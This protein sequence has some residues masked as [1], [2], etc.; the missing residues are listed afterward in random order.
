MFLK[1]FQCNLA[2]VCWSHAVRQWS[3]GCNRNVNFYFCFLLFTKLLSSTAGCQLKK[4]SLY[5]FYQDAICKKTAPI[6]VLPLESLYSLSGHRERHDTSADTNT[7]AEERIIKINVLSQ[8]TKSA[9]TC[10][11]ETCQTRGGIFIL[12]LSGLYIHKLVK[13]LFENVWN[14]RIN[15]LWQGDSQ[16]KHTLYKATLVGTSW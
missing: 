1:L 8:N 4:F 10:N 12:T 16:F 14:F 6:L 2:F 7:R 9:S 13:L 11:T 15:V 5:L 3:E